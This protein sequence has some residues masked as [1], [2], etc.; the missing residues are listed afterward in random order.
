MQQFHFDVNLID[1]YDI[2]N[3]IVHDGN[4]IAFN[5]TIG[6][7][8]LNNGVY[9]LS[10]KKGSGK[11]YLC[12]IFK[13]VQ[14]AIFIDI[15][16][17]CEI[18]YNKKYILE[19]LEDLNMEEE[20]L[21]FLINSIMGHNSTLLIT[22]KKQIHDFEF[23]LKDL[24]SRFSNIYNFILNDIDD[25]SKYKILL[26]LCSD[27]QISIDYDILQEI[28]NK[29]SNNYEVLINFVNNLEMMLLE[30]KIKKITLSNIKNLIKY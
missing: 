21:F 10:G 27:K 26:K 12:N 16:N 28:S 22:S 15:N 19:N 11:T 25:D 9:L 23:K 5:F 13:K 20:K 14:S 29:L 6:S 17:M 18:E 8:I 30:N 3:F 1:I 2:E 4:R 7:F 24:Q